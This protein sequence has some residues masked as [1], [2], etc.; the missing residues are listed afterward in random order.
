MGKSTHMA[1]RHSPTKSATLGEQA[2]R[3]NQAAGQE[4]ERDLK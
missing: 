4:A 3:E 2:H 1:R